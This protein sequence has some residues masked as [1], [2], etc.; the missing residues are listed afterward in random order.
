MSKAGI[1]SKVASAIP[2]TQQLWVDKYQPNCAADLVGNS[3]SIGKFTTW[4]KDWNDVVIM[5]RKKKPPPPKRGGSWANVPNLNARACMISGPP[6]IGKSS[7]VSIIAKEH[8]FGVMSI[9]ASDKRSKQVI[10]GMLKELC[11]SSTMDYFFK[12]DKQQ[13]DIDRKKRRENEQNRKTV[14][15]MDE[16]DGCGSS[17]RGGIAALI[18]VIKNTRMPVVCISN[19][20]SSRKIVSLINHCYDLRFTK[21]SANDIVKRLGMIARKEGLRIELSGLEKI[22]EFSGNDIRQIINLLQLWKTTSRE[23]KSDSVKSRHRSM[24]KDQKIMVN[25]F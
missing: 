11:E 10:E 2:T 15:V 17:D 16:V 24:Q 20:H 25:S 13:R 12:K 7:M 18:K 22:I 4:L 5:G 9:N 23:V 3:D 1:E 19:D 21:P 6:G 8:G 14:I